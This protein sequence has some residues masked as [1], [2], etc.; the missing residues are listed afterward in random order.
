MSMTKPQTMSSFFD[1]EFVI[2][3]PLSSQTLIIKK[4]LTDVLY[5]KGD[6]PHSLVDLQY[7]SDRG[8]ESQCGV[9]KVRRK[10]R[11]LFLKQK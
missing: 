9:P 1:F 11:G 6:N 3:L 4:A 8:R 5:A 10:K 7:L 2:P